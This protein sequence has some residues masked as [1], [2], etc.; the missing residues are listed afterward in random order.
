M[1]R[2][3]AALLAVAALLAACG[4]DDADTKASDTTTPAE[5]PAPKRIVS[6]SATATEML[7]AIGA[8]DQVVAV[9]DYSNYPAEAPT[10][11]LSAPTRTSR[12]SAPTTPT[13]S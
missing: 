10:T 9:D 13:S 3:I 2:T 7:F 4:S 8:G 11:D 12:P 5:G 1:K 6:L